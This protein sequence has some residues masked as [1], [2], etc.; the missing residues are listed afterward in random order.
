MSP[1]PSAQN[2]FPRALFVIYGLVWLAMAIAPRDWP[3]WALENLPVIVTVAILVA[4]RTRFTF[5]PASYL[6]IVLFLLL[7][8]YGAR[9]G[10]ANTPAG[11][12]ARDAF[13]LRRNYYDRVVHC[14]FGLL[15]VLPIRELL[16]RSAG[17]SRVAAGWLAWA[18]VVAGSSV[19]EVLEA[20]LAETISPGAGPDWLGA[21]GDEWDAQLDMIMATAG[22]GVTL[23]VVW[24]R[25]RGLFPPAPRLEGT[26]PPFRE[27]RLLHA[28]GA[29][30][31]IAWIIAAIRP[32]SRADWLLENFL[33]FAGMPV[34][35][36]TYRRRPLSD[37]SYALVLAFFLLHVVGA[38][39]TYSEVP[40]GHWLED[41][42][43]MSRNHFDRIVHFCW[44]FLL[45]YPMR[46]LMRLDR[47]RPF[48]SLFLP[49][50]IIISWSG[51]YE[52]IEA[53][54]AWMV[55]PE[56]GQAYLGTQGDIWD[57]QRD[58]GLAILGSAVAVAITA[59]TEK[60]SGRGQ[61]RPTG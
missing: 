8:T 48:W 16:L 1:E 17:V 15:L 54:A 3:T 49:S 37:A 56:L 51:F 55:N 46:D 4:T 7:H 61:R 50:V 52:I 60:A 20:F 59:V 26:Q 13:G 21:Q 6:L 43:G 39:Y 27:R 31:A 44:G 41:A 35:V 23:L 9:Y 53:V 42:L 38:H 33:V 32:V 45:T 40:F 22:A 30:Y 10:Y 25:E 58:M 57:G 29:L 14:A 28:M 11:N 19:F 5:S 36:L 34:L 47:L 18:L 2:R 12:W 24:W